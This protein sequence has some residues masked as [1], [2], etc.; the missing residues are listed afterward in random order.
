MIKIKITWFTACGFNA[1]EFYTTSK[2]DAVKIV[3]QK[4]KEFKLPDANDAEIDI[5]Y[6]NFN[7]RSR[8]GRDFWWSFRDFYADGGIIAKTYSL[9][10]MFERLDA[11]NLKA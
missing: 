4:S 5:R 2:N 3:E 6:E 11:Y 1:R 10:E 8:G 7:I 9:P